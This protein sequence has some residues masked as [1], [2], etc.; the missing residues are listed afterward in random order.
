MKT[1]YPDNINP[2]AL[3]IIRQ[4]II[5]PSVA[6]VTYAPFIVELGCSTGALGAKI[7]EEIPIATWLGIDCSDMALAIASKRLSKVIKADLNYITVGDL[8]YLEASPD[9][10]VL[11]DVL[12]HVY[13]PSSLIDKVAKAFPNAKI[14]CVLPNIACYQTYDRLSVQDFPYDDHGIFDKS[15]RTFYTA[16]SA[17]R[18]F[19]EAGYAPEAGPVFL[20]DPAVSK[21]QLDIISYPY[22]FTRERYSVHVQSKEDLLSL[23]SYG[24]GFLFKP[25]R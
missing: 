17:V 8:T 23:L 13:E 22:L 15:H 4:C 7:L 2:A 21:I 16:K 14:L 9:L 19:N 6:G 1:T 20:L 3:A 12:E 5:M 10:V 25:I 18:F 24:F 11:V